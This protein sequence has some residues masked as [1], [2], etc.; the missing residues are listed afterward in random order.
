MRPYFF[1]ITIFLSFNSFALSS[2][3]PEDGSRRMGR[4]YYGYLAGPLMER[5]AISL[6]KEGV[7]LINFGFEQIYFQ[8]VSLFS[9]DGSFVVQG[10]YPLDEDVLFGLPTEVLDEEYALMLTRVSEFFPEKLGI[11]HRTMDWTIIDGGALI[12]G[13]FKNGDDYAI[14]DQIAIVRVQALYKYIEGKEISKEFALKLIAKD[15][16]MKSE[17]LFP[18]T[19]SGHLDIT[20]MA[21]P[22][23]VILLNDS[24]MVPE[25][26]KN[27]LK[28]LTRKQRK[29]ETDIK[30]ISGIIELYKEGQQRY[31][32]TGKPMGDPR[33]PNSDYEILELDIIEKI[34]ENRFKVIRVPG[35]FKELT[36]YVNMSGSYYI[37]NFINFFNGFLGKNRLQETF[38][39]TNSANGIDLLEDFWKDILIK[40]GISNEHIYFSGSYSNGAGIDCMGSGAGAL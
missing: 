2:L 39:I 16:N 13:K 4:W 30:R 3:Y 32:N 25:A 12:T 18:V 37:G 35:V 29:R 6:K 17:N 27:F 8:D 38:V 20:M 10:L 21:L 40:N 9:E 33:F 7:E 24:K 19:S 15:F 23:G 26:L 1:I 22:G 11:S 14:I 34:L 5:M 36:E 31:Y 28:R